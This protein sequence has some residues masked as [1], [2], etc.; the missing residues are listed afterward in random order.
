[1]YVRIEG[2]NYA[3]DTIIRAR[4][5]ATGAL[6]TYDSHCAKCT[7]S[8]GRH[9]RQQAPMHKHA[10]NTRCRTCTTKFTQPQM[11]SLRDHTY[12]KRDFENRTHNSVFIKMRCVRF[13]DHLACTS[14][15][16]LTTLNLELS[17]AVK[18]LFRFHQIQPDRLC[19]LCNG[20]ESGQHD[21]NAKQI[22]FSTKTPHWI[23]HTRFCTH[24]I[25]H[26]CNG[27]L[28]ATYVFRDKL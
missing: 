16:G 9:P 2:W 15:G 19:H 17:G 28:P 12:R 25:V 21:V 27:Q 18:H 10:P 11:R 20:Q 4:D 24:A 13:T 3:S 22:T 14:Q 8:M 1:M 23:S 5:F 26:T 7:L 6:R